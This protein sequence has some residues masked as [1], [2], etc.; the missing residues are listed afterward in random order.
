MCFAA[1]LAHEA[2]RRSLIDA[3][4]GSMGVPDILVNN[5]GLYRLTPL[6]VT[7]EGAWLATFKTLIEI[8]LLAP[9]HLAYLTARAMIEQGR[10]GRII[11]IGSRGAYRGEPDAPG[12]GSAKAGLH[13]LTQ[14]LALALGPHHISV[15][16]VAPGW[17]ETDMAK[18]HLDGPRGDEI[19]N[20]SPLGRVARP[21]EV[22]AAV[23][24][25]AGMDAE[26]ATGAVLDLNGASYLR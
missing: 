13:A 14:S 19:R 15:T 1:D 11:N 18:A 24:Y 4:K 6:A 10:P 5:A 8:N 22:A 7:N 2:A 12:Y 20:Q 3:V 9:A 23:V 25:L 17:V 21:D 26:Y 16:A